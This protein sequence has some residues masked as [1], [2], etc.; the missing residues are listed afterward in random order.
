VKCS[1]LRTKFGI[2]VGT[3]ARDGWMVFYATDWKHGRNFGRATL[4]LTHEDGD[5]YNWDGREQK[6]FEN[7]I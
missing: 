6:L 7:S 3:K 2:Y 1:V 4:I 5:I